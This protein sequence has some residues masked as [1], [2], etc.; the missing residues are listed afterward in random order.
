MNTVPDTTRT[1]IVYL[2]FART[3]AIFAVLAIHFLATYSG[4]VLPLF[5]GKSNLTAISSPIFFAV[6]G[7][8]LA[9][10]NPRSK[11][12]NV[13]KFYRRRLLRIF[14]IFYLT[15]T[16]CFVI[17][18][19]LEHGFRSDVPIWHILFTIC[20]VDGLVLNF[21]VSS[22]YLVGE[23]FLGCIVMV[24]ILFPI[25]HFLWRLPKWV[26]P[27]LLAVAF[28]IACVTNVS[29]QVNNFFVMPL[30]CFGFGIV[31]FSRK[32]MWWGALA[33]VLVLAVITLAGIPWP[34]ELANVVFG[35]SV[36]YILYFL[37]RAFDYLPP[38]SRWLA[39]FSEL[40]F[41]IILTHHIIITWMISSWNPLGTGGRNVLLYVIS[42]LLILTV[43]SMALKAMERRLL[44]WI[45]HTAV[46]LKNL[47]RSPSKPIPMPRPEESAAVRPQ[48]S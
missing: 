46:I 28:V 40:S 4:Y 3:V 5:N 11:P 12:L 17:S 31:V 20:G 29:F 16:I 25:F 22:F 35:C 45:D 13:G 14:P 9:L 36:T 33:A 32:P 21:G 1:R 34:F 42:W 6:S 27:S 23:W 19:F 37:G 26:L 18:F 48:V 7:S 38:I 47:W 39:W 2:D 43:A 8:A 24:Y 10:T 41:A 30:I 15:Y 44:T